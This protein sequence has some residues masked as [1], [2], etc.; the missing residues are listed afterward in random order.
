MKYVVLVVVI[1]AFLYLLIDERRVA[2]IFL[3]IVLLSIYGA[4]KKGNNN[5][6]FP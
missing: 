4:F 1:I 3:P 5:W 6:P 2:V